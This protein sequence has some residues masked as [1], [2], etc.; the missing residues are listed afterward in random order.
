MFSAP[1]Y[2]LFLEMVYIVIEK[3]TLEKFSIN[4]VSH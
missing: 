3:V 4:D 1:Y 2:I